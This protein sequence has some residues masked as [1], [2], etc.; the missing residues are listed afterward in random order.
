MPLLIPFLMTDASYAGTTADADRRPNTPSL[1]Q[2]NAI[3]LLRWQFT[4]FELPLKY[5][6]F[7]PCLDYSL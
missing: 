6:Q 2:K 4:N 5:G 3:F 1:C 7:K